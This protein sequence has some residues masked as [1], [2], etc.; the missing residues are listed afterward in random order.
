MLAFNLEHPPETIQFVA[1]FINVNS[2]A[3]LS[4]QSQPLVTNDFQEADHSFAPNLPLYFSSA[5]ADTSIFS[6]ITCEANT[7]LPAQ[8]ITVAAKRLILP[9]NHGRADATTPVVA[10][11]ATVVQAYPNNVTGA[12]TADIAAS[13]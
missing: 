13:P 12:V 11:H 4:T 2:A 3:D 10:L 7:S 1:V 5:S 6:L 8:T 9:Y